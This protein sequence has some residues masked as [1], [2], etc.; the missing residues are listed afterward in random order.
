MASRIRNVKQYV[1]SDCAG[2]TAYSW[3]YDAYYCVKCD[4]WLE[5]ACGEKD[6]WCNCG[7]RPERPSLCKDGRI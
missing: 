4:E 2:E 6:C 3:F 1:C 5:K 7:I